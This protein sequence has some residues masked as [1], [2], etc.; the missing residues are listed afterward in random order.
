MTKSEEI[1]KSSKFEKELEFVQLLC[2]P[3]YLKWLHA[4]KYFSNPEF[5]E[6]LK[7]LLYFKDEK[8]LKFLIYPQCIPILELLLQDDVNSHLSE[9]SFYSK[10]AD[11]QH[12]IWK[13]RK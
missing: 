4:E 13:H 9:E 2:N 7:Y 11:D 5:K 6:F 3:D 10:L 1:E 12:F 8:Y